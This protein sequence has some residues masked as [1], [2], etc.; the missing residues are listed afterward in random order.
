M[1]GTALCSVPVCN[2]GAPAHR[3]PPYKDSIRNPSQIASVRSVGDPA[4]LA[5]L[6][7]GNEVSPEMRGAVAEDRVGRGRRFQM[8]RESCVWGRE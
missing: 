5:G 4:G 2:R 6:L 3:A 8:Q 7:C 1:P